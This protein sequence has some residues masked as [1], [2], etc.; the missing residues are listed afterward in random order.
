[1]A[2]TRRNHTATHLLHAALRR[3]L[4]DHVLQ[5]GSLVAPDRL[6]F[7]YSHFAAPDAAQLKT[8]EDDVNRAVLANFPVA[9]ELRTLEDARQSGAIALFGEKYEDEVRVIR[10]VDAER[11]DLVSAELCGGTHVSR[12][13]DIGL[14]RIVSDE[15]IASGTRRME[16][17]TG[18]LL[19]DWSRASDA[20][21]GELARALN[22]RPEDTAAR[23]TTL[24]DE[25]ATLRAALDKQ[26]RAGALDAAL[27]IVERKV[28]GQ[29]GAWVVGRLDGADPAALRD[30]ADS[31]RGALGSGAAAF[32]VTAEGKVSW[33]VIVTTDL[34]QAKALVAGDVLKAADI[35]GGG[36]P[37][38]AQGGG[39]DVD[40]VPEQLRKMADFLAQKLDS[41]AA[42]TW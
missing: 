5:A 32:A 13:G 34:A 26:A 1:R 14:F 40:R 20:R 22:T 42:A 24:L 38:F 39:Q 19:V 11:G 27:A 25:L 31:V 3:V 17:V 36:R 18:Q 41:A 8:V 21:I 37:E 2:A 15:S 28:E 16:A 35:K 23:V 4:G 6:R 7:D 9:I 29:K 12:T 33:I 10:I 30:A